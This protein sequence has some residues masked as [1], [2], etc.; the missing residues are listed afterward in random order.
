MPAGGTNCFS[1]LLH[2]ASYNHLLWE[3]SS[4]KPGE[5]TRWVYPSISVLRMLETNQGRRQL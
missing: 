4:V 1:A 3:L 5:V 2:A